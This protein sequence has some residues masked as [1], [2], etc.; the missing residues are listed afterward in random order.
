[1]RV[2][3]HGLGADLPPGW[4]ARIFRRR[5]ERT[6]ADTHPI[7]HAGNFALPAAAGD[8]GSG[9]VELMS[10]N[11]VFVSLKEFAPEAAGLPLFA[12][13]GRPTQLPYQSFSPNA[14]QRAIKG[15][16][17]AQFFF[18]EHGRPFC[19]YVVLG[20]YVDRSGLTPAANAALAGIV[21]AAPAG[22]AAP[23]DEGAQ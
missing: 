5:P 8:Y 18:T 22:S 16:A 21:I 1:M 19:L 2:S 12:A 20:S 17:G 10:P 9:A 3:A 4:D 14:L 7:L 23:P 13:Q 11:S 6:A 15:H